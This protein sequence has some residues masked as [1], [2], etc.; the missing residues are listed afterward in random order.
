[1]KIEEIQAKLPGYPGLRYSLKKLNLEDC[2]ENH[3]AR[4]FGYPQR[5]LSNLGKHLIQEE[6]LERI[7]S[8]NIISRETRD[9]INYLL[10]LDIY[11]N[12]K[13]NMGEFA[14]SASGWLDYREDKASKL[15]KLRDSYEKKYNKSKKSIED[16]EILKRLFQKEAERF[17]EKNKEELTKDYGFKG[18]WGSPQNRGILTK[19]GNLW[20]T[21]GN[22]VKAEEY[23]Q[24]AG[25]YEW[26]HAAGMFEKVRD[27]QRA[28]KFW[29]LAAKNPTG[30]SD[31]V[32]YRAG[33]YWEKAGNL[34]EAIKSFKSAIGVYYMQDG[35]HDLHGDPRPG[36]GSAHVLED[37]I[38][39][40]EKIIA[41]G[42]D[43]QRNP[44]AET[45][46]G[47]FTF[48]M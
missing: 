26:A 25:P 17:D 28:V 22:N 12:L 10:A 31:E 6:F 24:K 37:R 5:E 36:V 7:I 16:K 2:T 19:A 14:N 38:K 40:L 30:Y 15:W 11:P 29:T 34:E 35:G 1:M 47:I 18:N 20:I 44:I 39:V 43:K 13:K 46:E 48:P 45:T 3:Y 4:T 42:K 41:K 21:A 9:G 23:F 32:D 27:E 33:L 8:R